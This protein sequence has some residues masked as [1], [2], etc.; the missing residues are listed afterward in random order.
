MRLQSLRGRLLLDDMKTLATLLFLFS[1]LW[2]D[3][4]NNA[5]R[6]SISGNG[7]TDDIVL[8]FDSAGT[9][10]YNSDLDAW[11]LFSPVASIGQLYVQVS[12]VEQ[13]SIY[14]MPLS[15][16]D[17]CMDL[18]ALI[19]IAG[20]YTITTT[21]I[22]A[23]QSGEC[24]LLEDK[25][26]GNR[27]D[28]SSNLS[29]TFTF[30]QSTVGM[31]SRFRIRFRTGPQTILRAASCHNSG[32]GSLIL[33]QGLSGGWSGSLNGGNNSSISLPFSIS[34]DTL[35][36]L[37]A[38]IYILR[39]RDTMGCRSVDSLVIS[40]PDSIIAEFSYLDSLSDLP[41]GKSVSFI[42]ESVNAVSYTWDF[43]DATDTS[44]QCNPQH[45]YMASGAH[46]VTLT[47]SK[48]ACK[49]KTQRLLWIQ[50]FS[51]GLNLSSSTNPLDITITNQ[52]IRIFATGLEN[53]LSVSVM[54]A[55]GR[56]VKSVQTEKTG[57]TELQTA[58]LPSATYIVNAVCGQVRM[59]KK[60]VK[61]TNL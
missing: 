28:L 50:D 59:V 7:N 2:G 58:D 8:R 18:Y 46:P 37:S 17:T 40:E 10:A 39:V 41:V 29:L 45:R 13:L 36:N 52:T 15:S 27:Y 4:M 44:G 42:N 30:S 6:L 22:A 38:G 55:D 1:S 31:P 60:F 26:T 11:K 23:F 47:A 53:P 43:G 35:K 32:D 21:S 24:M 33:P 14:A 49:A 61:A 25:L 16:L 34:P 57:M 51:T 20:N 12:P 5:L 9:T 48:G 56:L 54:T 3:A 19:G